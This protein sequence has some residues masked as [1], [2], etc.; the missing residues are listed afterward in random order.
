MEERIKGAMSGPDLSD[1]SRY[2]R[3]QTFDSFCLS[4]V[5]DFPDK[6]G[7][8][9]GFD[10][11]LTR[12]VGLEV[13]DTVNR[14]TFAGFLDGFLEESG[15]RYG[16]WGAVAQENREGLYD[17]LN[18]MMSRGIYPIKGGEWFGDDAFVHGDSR[19][20]LSV[21][22]DMNIPDK[23]NSP[24]QKAMMKA[25]KDRNAVA[26][27]PG[28]FDP[29]AS[30]VPQSILEDAA[31]EDRS[32]LI[33]LVHDVFAGYIEDCMSRDHLTFGMVAMLAFSILYIDGDA[34]RANSFRYLMIDEFQDTNAAQL[35]MSLMILREPNLC[36]VG[37]WRQGIY[38]FRYVSIE[39][40]RRFEERTAELGA[41]LNA[42]GT[43]RVPFDIPDTLRLRFDTNYRS[44]QRI[45]DYAFRCLALKATLKEEPTPYEG[46][47]TDGLLSASD[48]AMEGL[49]EVRFVRAEFNED[50]AEMVERCVREYVGSGRYLKL[51]VRTDED[52]MVRTE[53]RP[54]RFGDIAVLCRSTKACREVVGRLERGGVPVFMQGDVEIMSTREGKLALAWLRYVGNDADPRGIG[55]IMAD[56]G[57][58]MEECMR[59]AKRPALV[60]SDIRAQRESLRGK[61]RRVN[62]LLTSVFSW[63]GI[64]DDVSQAIINVLS[65]MHSG[66]LLTISDLIT[67]M[68]DDMAR[69]DGGRAVYPV[70]TP[71]GSDAVTVMTMHKA[72]GLEFPAVIIPFVDSKVM[73]SSVGD[74]SVFRFDRT[75]GIRC[76]RAVGRFGDYSKLCKSWR[77]ALVDA[78][79]EPDRNSQ[80]Y[81]EER[82]LMFVAM[83]RAKQYETVICG[84]TPSEFMK[85]LCSEPMTEIG[86]FELPDDREGC[87][88]APEPDLRGYVKRRAALAVHDL[89]VLDFGGRERDPDADEATAERRG[90]EYGTKVHKEAE[91]M[92]KTGLPRC[93]LEES[94]WIRDNVLC[95]IRDPWDGG[96]DYVSGYIH[97]YSE[98]GCTL[99]L[100]DPDVVIRG[101]IDLLILFEDRVEIHDYKTDG[102]RANEDQYMLQLSVYARVAESFY[103]RQVR[104]FIDY[105][106]LEETVE[107]DPLPMDTIKEKA[108]EALERLSLPASNE[109]PDIS[110]EMADG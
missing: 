6:A 32:G 37:D 66:S 80:R 72:K 95:R 30:V 14:R 9:F 39:Y 64:S 74:R 98:L 12:S 106:H 34:R 43:K 61:R 109:T 15:G 92:H 49:T 63:Y 69:A 68:E 84:S 102:S 105:A 86:W 17:L 77:T 103:G 81:D 33:G 94:A 82:R 108:R 19:A 40:L 79:S 52:G 28:S 87:A 96:S 55:A 25:C 10:A 7:E 57:Y 18:R 91:D 71:F 45:V 85:G 27:V 47:E 11:R 56:M 73:P 75:G 76:T 38:G 62:E 42:D 60:P 22:T 20:L 99:P 50:E 29:D 54:L 23:K 53:T 70:E 89:M 107:F 48:V 8:L 97:S 93:T 36:V 100:D 46:Q 2:V 110:G 58:T 21:M 5:M 13:N 83:S 101:I 16:D 4:V 51:D 31:L 1:K 65:G 88:G 104:C 59:A 35:M 90:K 67:L 41:M 3:V 26:P 78:V 24:M 44:S